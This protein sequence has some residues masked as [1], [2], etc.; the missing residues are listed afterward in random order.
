MNIR[1]VRGFSMI[2]LLVA[3]LVMG[4]GV[5]GLSGLQL[6]SLQNG[7]TS[8]SR[9]AAVVLAYDIVDRMRANRGAA[10]GG[11]AIGASPPAATN[12]LANNCTDTQMAAF[13]QAV[14]KCALGAYNADNT[15]VTLRAAGVLPAVQAEPGLPSGD[16]SITVNGV[17]NVVAVSVRWQEPNTSSPVTVAVQTR[18]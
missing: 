7:R 6:V 11:L 8:V 10:Y 14:W 16:G 13:D 3:V 12:C 5:L 4:I 15:C 1:H 18:I 17:T 2:E 9:G